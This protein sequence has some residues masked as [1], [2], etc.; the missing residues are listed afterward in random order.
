MTR[1]P[2]VRYAWNGDVALAYQ[3][4]GAGPVDLVYLQGYA[5]HVDLNWESQYL[6]R[7]LRGLGERIDLSD[8]NEWTVEANP[9]TVT[10]E[11]CQML[12]AS[13]VDRRGRGVVGRAPGPVRVDEVIQGPLQLLR[14]GDD[15]LATR[16]PVVGQGLGRA[17]ALKCRCALE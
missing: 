2:E 1:N 11:Y 12:R 8:V 5:S 9:A 15:H 3:V 7:F 6:A 4:F 10:A 16:R 17:A 14:R 13:G